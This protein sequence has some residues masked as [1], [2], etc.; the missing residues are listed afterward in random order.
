[1]SEE[2]RQWHLRSTKWY[3]DQ[4]CWLMR[5][6]N[7]SWQAVLVMAICIHFYLMQSLNEYEVCSNSILCMFKRRM[8]KDATF[9]CISF[10]K[11]GSPEWWCLQILL[12]CSHVC[13]YTSKS[14][15]F[16]CNGIF[17]SMALW[18]SSNRFWKGW[19]HARDV[20]NIHIVCASCHPCFEDGSCSFAKKDR[21]RWHGS[22]ILFLAVF[23]EDLWLKEE[24]HVCGRLFGY[25]SKSLCHPC[26]R[27]TRWRRSWTSVHKVLSGHLFKVTARVWKRMS[28][29]FCIFPRMRAVE[30]IVFDQKHVLLCS[31]MIEPRRQF[32][33]I[34]K[35]LW[36]PPVRRSWER[37]WRASRLFLSLIHIWRC[38][39]RG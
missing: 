20:D 2:R 24:Y 33:K 12:R 35:R 25:T 36:A 10:K 5:Y 38:R 16:F 28:T 29:A 15:V 32:A 31:Q 7:E 21:H 11:E 9:V 23:A 17:V 8:M 26:R 6:E 34:V 22:K 37:Y 13:G 4:H 27:R 3:L 18:N 1:M 39:R 19:N 30:A 14:M